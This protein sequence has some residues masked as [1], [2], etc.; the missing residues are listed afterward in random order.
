MY[1]SYKKSFEVLGVDHKLCHMYFNYFV[2]SILQCIKNRFNKN[3]KHVSNHENL[4]FTFFLW[5]HHRT[6]PQP[7]PH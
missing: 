7:P 3:F 1:F 6:P 5:R 2:T 4:K